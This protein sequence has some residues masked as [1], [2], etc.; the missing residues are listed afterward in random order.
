MMISPLNYIDNLKDKTYE[1][2]LVERD[3]LL[4][5]IKSF[6]QSSNETI[7]P[8]VV[9]PGPDVKYQVYLDYLSELCKL[10]KEKYRS[11]K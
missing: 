5:E 6:E 8:I 2:L 7:I 10:I 11:K 1:E 3:R 4:D 9:T